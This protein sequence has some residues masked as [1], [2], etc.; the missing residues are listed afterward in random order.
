MLTMQMVVMKR[1]TFKYEPAS[2]KYQV[3]TDFPAP[4]HLR[5]TARICPRGYFRMV[6]K[7]NPVMRCFWIRTPRMTTGMVMTVPIA[8][9]GP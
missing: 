2:L 3:K 1:V 4:P 5:A 9:C 7:L 8:A 6:P